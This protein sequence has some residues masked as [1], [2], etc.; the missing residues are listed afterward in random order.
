[1]NY[2]NNII[3]KHIEK[4]IILFILIQPILDTITGINVNILKN[5]FPFAPITRLLFMLLGIY[6]ILFINK[7]QKD[8]KKLI[9]IF[10]YTILFWIMTIVYKGKHSL[11]Y[12]TTNLLNTLYLPII[13]ISLL[14]IFEHK[15]IKINLKT[16]LITYFI[17]IILI[18]IPDITNTAFNSYSHSKTGHVGWFP[19]ANV[20]GNILSIL[21]PIIIYY[22][23]KTK[24]KYILKTIM[25]LSIIYVFFNI[26]TKVPI[27]SLLICIICNLFYTLIKW[28]K[29]KKYKNIIIS[30]II[31]L[32]LSTMAL[33]LIPKTSFYK[34]LEIHKNYLGIN[35]YLEIFTKYELIDHFIFSQ[36][37]TFLTTIHNSNKTDIIQKLIGIGYIKKYGI[38]QS[39]KTIEIDYFDILYE[40]GIIGTLL[41]G[42]ILLPI[43][44]ESY[45]KTKK[46]SLINTNYKICITLILLIALFAGHILIS[47]AIGIFVALI[48][49]IILKGG[50]NENTKK[51]QN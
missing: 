19:L 25:I 11:I 8:I 7:N 20:I 24:K 34:N 47:P 15:K 50:L 17:Y 22:I 12:E 4:I 10:I 51:R 49:T 30:I 41:L 26:G 23:L 42:Y 1:M 3:E 32:I 2:I 38:E 31:T 37:L 16:I 45:K 48:F 5:N 27:I 29:T 44:I 35:N 21:L 36:R 14:N 33:L 28:I 43:I 6:Y 40:N 13:L 18:I 9:M 46:N 39:T